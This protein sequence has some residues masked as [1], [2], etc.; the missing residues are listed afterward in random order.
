MTAPRI[1]SAHQVTVWVSPT[2]VSGRLKVSVGFGH[3]TKSREGLAALERFASG[4]TQGAVR[5][6]T[7]TR[8]NLE[9]LQDLLRGRAESWQI[10]AVTVHELLSLQ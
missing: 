1:N 9:S 3:A 10:H 8:G 7:L 4:E 2:N 6:M 5:R